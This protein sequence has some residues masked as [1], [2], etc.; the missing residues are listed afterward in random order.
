MGFGSDVESI[1]I[2]LWLILLIPVLSSNPLREKEKIQ[3]LLVKTAVKH[4]LLTDLNHRYGEI[5]VCQHRGTQT[6]LLKTPLIF[7][8]SQTPRI[9]LQV[10]VVAEGVCF[11]G[12]SPGWQQGMGEQSWGHRERGDLPRL[13]TGLWWGQLGGAGPSEDSMGAL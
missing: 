11:P 9:T 2:T 12:T 1:I 5:R 6:Q 13:G 8:A 4:R 3:S 7:K 10:V